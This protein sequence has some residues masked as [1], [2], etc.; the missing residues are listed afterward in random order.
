MVSRMEKIVKVIGE[1]ADCEVN[2]FKIVVILNVP[3]KQL[4]AEIMV[5]NYKRK[6]V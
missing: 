2:V 6:R 3:I 4:I 5:K 1:A